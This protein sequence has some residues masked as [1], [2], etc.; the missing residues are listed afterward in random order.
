M[1]PLQ[2]EFAKLVGK[3]LAR[4]WFNEQRQRAERNVKN[5]KGRNTA[6]GSPSDEV[7]GNRKK[8]G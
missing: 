3:I 7:S 6:L 5:H 1:T 8:E 4:R 2:K